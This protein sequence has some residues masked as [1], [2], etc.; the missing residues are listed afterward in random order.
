MLWFSPVIEKFA[1]LYA[2]E[3]EV[4]VISGG[5]I[6][7]DKIGPIGKVAPYISWAYKN[8]EEASDV[9]F[10]AN[11]LDKTLKNG[12]AIFT[13]I[14]AAIALCIVKEKLPKQSLAFAAALQKAIYFDGIEPEII[15]EYAKIAVTFGLNKTDFLN[16]MNNIK[17]KELA[18]QDFKQSQR[19]QVSGFPSV[20]LQTD[21]QYF[22]IAAGFTTLENLE[23]AFFAIKGV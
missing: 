23:K 22:K 3:F 10:G 9:K 14:P 15:E 17:Y 6:I 1:N 12:T 16:D 7:G 11:F 18:T 8:V 19:L 4:E 13:S 20:F 21:E 2:N 5:M